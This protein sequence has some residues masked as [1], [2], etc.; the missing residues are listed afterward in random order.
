VQIPASL[1]RSCREICERSSRLNCE[2]TPK[3]MPN[4]LAMGSVTPCTRE[5]TAFYRCLVAEPLP[6]WQCA[7]N[8]VAAIQPGFCDDEQRRTVACMEAKMR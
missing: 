4:C 5:M 3:C 8:G 6:H 1:E 7:P 2:N